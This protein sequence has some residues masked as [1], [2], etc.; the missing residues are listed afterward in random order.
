MNSFVYNFILIPFAMKAKELYIK[1][2]HTVAELN[3]QD[4]L[5][6]TSDMLRDFPDVRRYFQSR[7]K[8]LLIDEFQDTD[9]IQVGITMYLT[10]KELEEKRWNMITPNEGALFV[11]GDPKQSIYGFRRAD[12]T[13]YKRFKEHMAK[14]GGKIIELQTNFRAVNS[15]GEW[16]NKVFVDLL[17]GEE[18]A[19]FSAMDAVMPDG[20]DTLAGLAFYRV[21]EKKVADILEKEA[22][23]LTQI[24]RHLVGRKNIT[25]RNR[26]GEYI[27]RP[28]QYKDIMVLTMKKKQ[29]EV[30]GNGIARQGIP[31]KITGADITKQTS[32]FISFRDLGRVDT[33]RNQRI[34]WKIIANMK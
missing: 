20:K 2:K 28:I 31:V 5:M 30:I 8:T 24:I 19:V 12:F 18:Q 27:S 16:Y 14:T 29:L 7:Y 26:M 25:E 33:S 17:K 34:N 11:V 1:H 3:Y 6:K 13:M 22:E 4:L 23:I 21:E 10:G 32:E 9:P 15:L